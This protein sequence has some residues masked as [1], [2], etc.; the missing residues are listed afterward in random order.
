[1]VDPLTLLVPLLT[2]LPASARS[3]PRSTNGMTDWR[4]K[5]SALT[6]TILF[7]LHTVAANAFVQVVMM[8]R[9]TFIQ[10]SV[11]MMELPP[12][13]SHLATFDLL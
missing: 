5:N 8:L 2:H 3:S 12:L 6:T 1:M 10:D 7:N 9:K 13:P 11:F 4:Q